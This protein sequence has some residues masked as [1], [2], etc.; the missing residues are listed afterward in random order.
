MEAHAGG[1]GRHRWGVRGLVVK[2]LGWL[3]FGAGLFLLDSA[4]HNRAPIKTLQ[5]V[6]AQRTDTSHLQGTTTPLYV[7]STGS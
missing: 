2:L 5:L 1:Q 3:A 4:V 7:K 6:L